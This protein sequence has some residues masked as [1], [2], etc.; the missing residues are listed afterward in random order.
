MKQ[1]IGS[2]LFDLFNVIFMIV[3]ITV[4]IYPFLYVASAS[5]S[6]GMSILTGEVTFLP[7]K[8]T[9]NAYKRVLSD[10]TVWMGYRNTVLYTVVQVIFAVSIT[11]LM[12][13]PLSRT[14]L[15]FR[16]QIMMFIG[17][18][19]LFNGGL[20]PTFLV[21][22]TLGLYDT[23]WALIFPYAINTMY[24][25]IM[26]TFFEGL[27]PAYEEAAIIDGCGPIKTLFYVILPLS[28]P[29]IATI[30]LFTAL[31]KW[32]AFFSALIY[33]NNKNLFPLQL[34]LRNIILINQA[35]AQT[36][37]PDA[38]MDIGSLEAIKYAT[39]MV[40]TVPILMVYPFIQKYFAK[41]VAIGGIKG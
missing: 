40:A 2:R 17:F 5:F 27:P 41:G 4:M 29:I 25:F 15:L 20:I 18:T 10:Q 33:L 12:A 1:S 28:K 3:M 7:V 26:R 6:S 19:M 37:T 16:N 14:R 38:I 24:L 21:V 35:A 22:K 13:Y 32:N 36:E 8:F 39:I 31:N 9:L 11:S 30:A 34:H 23:F